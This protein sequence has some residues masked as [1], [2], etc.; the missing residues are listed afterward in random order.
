VTQDL[1]AAGHLD[2]ARDFLEEAKGADPAGFPHAVIHLCYYAMYH[3][4]AAA[5]MHTQGSA[6]TNHG[7]VIANGSDLLA[8]RF[9]TEGERAGE[10]LYRAYQLRL[11]VDYKADP[12]HLADRAMELREQ[13]DEALVLCAQFLDR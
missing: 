4:V 1:D 6:P 11:L 10:T 9:G 7:R 12:D 3:G 5:L 8:K 2:K 13:A